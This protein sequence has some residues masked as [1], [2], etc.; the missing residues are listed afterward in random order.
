MMTSESN[1]NELAIKVGNLYMDVNKK[2]KDEVDHGLE[3]IRQL[4]S[5]E[6]DLAALQHKV[7]QKRNQIKRKYG[8]I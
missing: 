2:L 4:A 6:A 7:D 3:D 8:D 1:M 5:F